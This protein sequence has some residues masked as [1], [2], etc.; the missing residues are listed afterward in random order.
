MRSHVTFKTPRFNQTEVQPHFINPC[1]FGE[2]C[3]IWLIAELRER[4]WADLTDPWQEDW[5][6][7]TSG[8]RDGRR[9]LLSVGLIP[10]DTPEWLAHIHERPPLLERLR[11]R[12]EL[13]VLPRLAPALHQVLRAAPDISDVR[14]HFENVFRRGGS[15]GSADPSAA[16]SAGETG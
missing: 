10:E 1:C 7:Q 13:I 3:I 5:G 8:Q 9:Y 12:G 6:W 11:G 15:D 16:R 4:G 2:D 14:W